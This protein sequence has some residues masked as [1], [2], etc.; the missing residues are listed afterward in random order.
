VNAGRLVL[1]DLT[2]A[3]GNAFTLGPLSLTLTEGV[4]CLVGPNGAGKST[5][6]RVAAK[7]DR[8]TSG[9]ITVENGA[10]SATLGYLPQEPLLPPSATCEDFLYHVAWLHRVPRRQRKDAVSS[11]LAA[12]GLTDRRA[13]RIRKLSG[14]MRRRL[15]IAHAIVHDPAIVLLDEPTVGLDPV[16]RVS[17]RKTIDT[18]SRNR[19]VLVSTHLVEDIRG[20]ADRVI[21]LNNGGVVYDGDIS[22]LEKRA[23][24]GAPGDTDLERAI[25]SLMGETS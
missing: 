25:A 8:P 17:L 14:G 22:T 1:R 19:V 21:I 13:T 9:S 5:L 6:F 18:V 3:Y 11:A 24:P 23:A 20:L 7:V 12:V 16:Q 10:G 4:T 15:G 2:K